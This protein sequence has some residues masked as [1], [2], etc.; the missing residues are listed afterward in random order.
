MKK[1]NIFIFLLTII[2]LLF[3]SISVNAAPPETDGWEKAMF[4][5]ENSR[6]MKRLTNYEM[7]HWGNYQYPDIMAFL[8]SL[9]AQPDMSRIYIRTNGG[10]IDEMVNEYKET[11]TVNFDN[12]EKTVEGIPIGYVGRHIMVPVYSQEKIAGLIAVF[13]WSPATDTPELI[14]VPDTGGGEFMSVDPEMGLAAT[15]QEPES[16]TYAKEGYEVLKAKGIVPV[17]IV[18]L[19]D[20][21]LGLKCIF[22][23][24][25]NQYYIYP[26]TIQ[27]EEGKGYQALLLEDYIKALANESII[28]GPIPQPTPTPELTHTPRPSKTAAA[29]SRPTVTVS[30]AT[31]SAEQTASPMLTAAASIL[32]SPSTQSNSSAADAV[33]IVLGVI[34]C[35]AAAGGIVWAVMS[36]RRKKAGK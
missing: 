9:D 17:N 19:N 12:Y 31:P 14:Y 20:Y 1:F 27:R 30:A 34:L 21:R 15:N 8:E 35:C 10:N 32:P 25:E 33:F 3:S 13:D 18:E 5:A 22:I 4:L 16:W 24:E 2:V 6:D 7:I 26:I 28:D 29:T 23:T 11:G 36:A